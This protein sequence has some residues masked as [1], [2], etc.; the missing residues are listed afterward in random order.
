MVPEASTS[1]LPM[2]EHLED[3]GIPKTLFT[4]TGYVCNLL[5]L[6]ILETHIISIYK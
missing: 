2:L 6:L 1:M 3:T 5:I 4:F